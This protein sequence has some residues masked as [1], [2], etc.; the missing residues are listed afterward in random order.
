MTSPYHDDLDEREVD[1]GEAVDPDAPE[2][3]VIA[4]RFETFLVKHGAEYR[5]LHEYDPRLVVQV[6][7]AVAVE[8][9]FASSIFWVDDEP[10][11]LYQKI[12]AHP[13]L[14]Q[15]L[16]GARRAGVAPFDLF[17]MTREWTPDA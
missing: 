13:E 16:V 17:F 7:I 5:Q 3:R 4:S 6:W 10:D 8:L 2:T 12:A 9:L 11:T 15:I 1:A 14:Q